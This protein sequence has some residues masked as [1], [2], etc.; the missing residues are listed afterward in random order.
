MREEVFD[1]DGACW[2]DE[3][4]L[5]LGFFFEEHL[6]SEFGQVL[7]DGVV[8]AEFAFVLKHHDCQRGHG[9]GHGGDPEEAVFL[10]RRP[11]FEILKS[12]GLATEQLVILPDERDGTGELAVFDEGLL[13]RRDGRKWN[14]L[15]RGLLRVH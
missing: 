9:F 2:F 10:H 12:D 4:G 11:G 8:D 6:A 1:G 3:H 14:G 13:T 7:H 5:V 15:R